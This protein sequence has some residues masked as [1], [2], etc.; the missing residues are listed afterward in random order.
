M[1]AV[2]GAV[3]VVTGASGGV[4][5]AIADALESAGARVARVSRHA[6]QFRCD[7][8]F[9]DE[10]DRL[11]AEVETELGRPQVLVNAAGI[12]GP[13]ALLSESE[14][15]R[16]IETIMVDL[17]GP[18][19]S[20]RAFVPGMIDAGWG[21][22][23]NVTSAAS[24]HPPGPTNS[25]Y[26]TAKTALNQ[27]TRHL[28]AELEGTGVTANVIHPGDV[29]TEMWADIR[30]QIAGSGPETEAYRQWVEWVEE[31]G[32]DPP[33]KAGDLVLRICEDDVN[34]KFLWIEDPLQAPIPSWGDEPGTQPWRR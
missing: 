9:R 3:A 2:D 25:A 16:W 11:K 32:G 12:F 7:I 26:G 6:D 15:E 4:G 29:K 14:P 10:V 23:V 34:G 19:L 33:E 5:G 13:I 20:C 8:G 22:I 24:L 28:A 1:S 31:T 18:Y 30:S 21:R 27:L 17:I